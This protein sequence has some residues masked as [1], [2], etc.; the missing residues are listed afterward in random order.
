MYRLR[1]MDGPHSLG[2]CRRP[3]RTRS[4]V[5]ASCLCATRLL[6]RAA[7]ALFFA[8]LLA[9]AR[10]AHVD[11]PRCQDPEIQLRLRDVVN[12]LANTLRFFSN[13]FKYR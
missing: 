3:D 13:T 11:L 5:S 2:V 7:A 10:P 4:A 8:G 12:N 1:G 6:R 9:A